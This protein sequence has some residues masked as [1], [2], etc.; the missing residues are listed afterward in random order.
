VEEDNDRSPVIMETHFMGFKLNDL[1]YRKAEARIGYMAIN[2]YD[3][4]SY[5]TWGKYND[6]KIKEVW[7]DGL[8]GDFRQRYNNC[9]ETTCIDVAIRPEWLKNLED[10]RGVIDGRKIKTIPLLE[11]TEEGEKAMEE[12]RLIMLGGNHRREAVG[13]YVDWLER[14]IKSG[15]AVVKKKEEALGSTFVGEAAREVEKL[16]DRLSIHKEVAEGARFW[17]VRLYD[18]GERTQ[19][20]T[21]FRGWRGI[22]TIIY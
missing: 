11:F 13:R 9:S 12:E 22:G 15:E 2:L 20:D 1:D 21:C 8:V 18:R 16:R 17:A 19:C 10:V 5:A 4:P 6:R 3:P 14:E 7:V